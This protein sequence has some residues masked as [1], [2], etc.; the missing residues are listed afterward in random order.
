MALLQAAPSWDLVITLAFVIG[1]TYG[2]IMLRDRVLVTLLSL[3]AGNVIA[4]TF[5]APIQKFFNGDTA[6]LNK[7]W[8]ESSASP[9]M[10]KVALF[11]AVIV[12]IGAKAGLV[13]KRSGFS[14][15]ELAAYSFFNVCIGLSTIFSFMSPEQLQGYTNASKLATFIVHHQMVWFIAPLL[16]LAVMSHSS[17]RGGG[18]GGYYGQDY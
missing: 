16:V 6:I 11:G 9:F 12:L 18:G 5:A 8:V 13:G 14:M 17:S 10:I 7:I 4:N 1:I 15:F 3:Y 2:F